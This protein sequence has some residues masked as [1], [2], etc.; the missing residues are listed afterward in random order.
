MALSFCDLGVK[1]FGSQPKSMELSSST[2]KSIAFSFSESGSVS[3][4]SIS[5]LIREMTLVFGSLWSLYSETKDE[6]LVCKA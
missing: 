1:N 4:S 6:S 2:Y 3:S 5:V